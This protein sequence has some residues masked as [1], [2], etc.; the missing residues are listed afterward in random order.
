MNSEDHGDLDEN[1][2]AFVKKDGLSVPEVQECLGPCTIAVIQCVFH[3]YEVAGMFILTA[4]FVDVFLEY[5]IS[6]LPSVVHVSASN[7]RLQP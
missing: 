2:D 5:G 1:S 6:S 4:F 3:K 7:L